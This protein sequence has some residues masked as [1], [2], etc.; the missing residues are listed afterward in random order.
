MKHLFSLGVVSGLVSLACSSALVAGCDP[1]LV[2]TRDDAG[3]PDS[4]PTDGGSTLDATPDASP[5]DAGPPQTVGCD[6]P[7]APTSYVHTPGKAIDYVVTCNLPLE[8]PT[9]IGPGTVIAFQD[10][11]GFTVR[12]AEGSLKAG[13]TPEAPIVLQAAK[14]GEK[15]M[16]IYFFTTSASNLLERVKISNA[17]GKQP[18]LS[19]SVIVGAASYAGGTVAIRDCVIEGS[20]G[21]GLS[22]G[23]GGLLTSLDRV[24]ISGGAGAPVEVNVENIGILGSAG[25]KFAG[26]ARNRVEVFET[27]AASKPKDQTWAKL[28]VPYFVTGH[29]ITHSVHT[30][31]P[32]VTILLGKDAAIDQSAAAPTS[33][34]VAI[35]TAAEPI[36]FG[37]ENA[38]AKWDALW[39]HNPGNELAHCRLSDGGGLGFVGNKGIIL[40]LAGTVSIRDCV[41]EGSAGW[42]IYKDND[43]PAPTVNVGANVTF[44][45]NALGDVSP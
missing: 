34:L 29:V 5:G 6:G 27:A 22:V 45:N 24:A 23:E 31:S 4:G 20:L 26:N 18:N 40:A 37:P 13:G 16:G 19:A 25:N 41:I 14:A 43:P 39:L 30:I 15:W 36:T 2:V 10:G 12:G 44:R 35:G 1:S 38:S 28:D 21:A 7:S 9:T 3:S 33:H 32:G 42:G 8:K 17:G 11:A